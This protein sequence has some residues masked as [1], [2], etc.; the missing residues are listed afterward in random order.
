[1]ARKTRNERKRMKSQSTF[2]EVDIYWRA[3]VKT[4]MPPGVSDLQLTEMRK[5]FISGFWTCLNEMLLSV[6]EQDEDLDVEALELWRQDTDK[7]FKELFK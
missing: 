3:F 4:A 6:G 1:M 7:A 2:K 5:A